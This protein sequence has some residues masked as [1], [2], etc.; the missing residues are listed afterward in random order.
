MKSW[1]NVC[2]T[3]YRASLAV[4]KINQYFDFFFLVVSA[5]KAAPHKYVVQNGKSTFRTISEINR[6]S[7]PIPSQI[8]LIIF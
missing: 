5:E 4:F 8:Y 3:R 2:T 1:L 7:N 6:N